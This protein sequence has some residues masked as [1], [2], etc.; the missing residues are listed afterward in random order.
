[1]Q[2][3]I[4]HIIKLSNI[5]MTE[6]EISLLKE[7]LENIVNWLEIIGKVDTSSVQPMTNILQDLNFINVQKKSSHKIENV[8]EILANAPETFENYFC[9]PKV[10]EDR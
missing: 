1:M 10:I 2:I 3:D 7:Q 8:K 9:I 4:N 5:K 6:Q